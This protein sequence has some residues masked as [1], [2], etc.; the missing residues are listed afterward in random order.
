MSRPPRAPDCH[1]ERKHYAKGLC[2]Q[3]YDRQ[4]DRGYAP[5]DSP[6]HKAKL[7][8]RF[9]PERRALQSEQKKGNQYRLGKTHSPETRAKISAKKRGHKPSPQ[10]RLN[11]LAATP[12][13][14]KQPNWKGDEAGYAP[15]HAWLIRNHPKTGVCEECGKE[16]VT[17]YAFKRHPEKHTRNREDYRELCPK[18]HR[19]FD[20]EFLPRGSKH[21][22]NQRRA[23]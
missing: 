1:P 23:A 21:W 7:R 15:K 3:C 2:A 10:A 5:F 22:R 16:G 13:G 18:C 6:A 12:R 14:E 19:T 8:A 4:R 20:A 9:T 11:Q 17:Q